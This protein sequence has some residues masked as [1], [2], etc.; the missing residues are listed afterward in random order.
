[1]K[2]E[3]I[4]KI[5][6]PDNGIIVQSRINRPDSGHNFHSHNYLSILF[7]V[8]GHGILQL[9][10]KNYDLK[11]DTIVALNAGL[12]H[13]FSDKPKKQM[14][15]FS[16]YFDVAQTGANKYIVDY[17]FS[18]NEP[19]VLPFYYAEQT[20]KNLRQM[21]YEQLKKPPGYKLGINH[22]FNI[23]LLNIY[24]A[25]LVFSQN[26]DLHTNNNNARVQAAL[27]YIA[28]NSHEQFSLNDAAK[29]A[30]VSHRQFT[31]L[32][33]IQA[34]KS[35]VKFLNQ[36]RCEKARKLIIGTDAS[37]A[38]IAFEAGYEDLSTF[39]RAFKSIYKATPL[40]LKNKATEH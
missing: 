11:P 2:S 8:S 29:M 38:S 20:R 17:L 27:E 12:L 39:Y 15:V 35:F 24:R 34:G 26:T 9:A 30:G 5:T 14:T 3:N 25:K 19:F 18:S 31:K 22:I 1:M 40:S 13:K 6:L 33:R 4:N 36:K 16:I 21:L 37:I 28:A 32:C 23:T 10:D 7:V